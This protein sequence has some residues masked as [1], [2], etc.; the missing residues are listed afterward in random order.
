MGGSRRSRATRGQPADLRLTKLT[1]GRAPVLVMSWPITA[2]SEHALALPPTITAAEA[3]I[4]ELM[5]EGRSVDEMAALR[6]TARGTVKKQIAAAYRKLGVGS[7][8]E[9]GVALAGRGRAG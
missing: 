3:A 4:V 5:L 2:R 7:R 9:L 1:I 8:G 6:G